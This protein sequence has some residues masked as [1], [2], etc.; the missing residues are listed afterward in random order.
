MQNPF[1]GMNPYLE[2]PAH[3]P[4]VHLSLI[5][6][7]RVA[8][9]RTLPPELMTRVEERVYVEDWGKNY[10]PDA[11]VIQT[12]PRLP[13]SNAAMPFYPPLYLNHHQELS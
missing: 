1:P 8:I 3:W 6:A 10:Y 5:Y 11:I 4:D 2:H 13:G 12:K 9:N 7:L